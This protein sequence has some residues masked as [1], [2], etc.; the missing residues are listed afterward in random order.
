[1]ATPYQVPRLSDIMY[2]RSR[3]PTPQQVTL[4]NLMSFLKS[5]QQIKAETE[6][7]RSHREFTKQSN[8]EEREW[9]SGEETKRRA[10]EEEKEL[11]RRFE[12]RQDIRR[13][14]NQRLIDENTRRA[15]RASNFIR[16]ALSAGK[17]E[18]ASTLLAGSLTDF[19]N[20]NRMQDVDRYQ[21]EIDSGRTRKSG[22]NRVNAKVLEV[23]RGVGEISA[24]L[25]TDDWTT[26]ADDND[27]NILLNYENRNFSHFTAVERIFLQ[28]KLK[29]MSA[30]EAQIAESIIEY[31]GRGAFRD[32]ETDEP[33][34]V[35]KQLY[36]QK[37]NLL[38]ER[39]SLKNNPSAFLP[40]HARNKSTLLD[41]GYG[42]E[43]LDDAIGTWIKMV[44]PSFATGPIERDTP[45]ARAYIHGLLEAGEAKAIYTGGKVSSIL[46]RAQWQAAGLGMKQDPPLD[47]DPKGPKKIKTIDEFTKELEERIQVKIED[48]IPAKGSSGVMGEYTHNIS[49][50]QDIKDPKG[51]EYP[52]A[53]HSYVPNIVREYAGLSQEIYDT[54]DGATAGFKKNINKYKAG[55]DNDVQKEIKTTLVNS[56]NQRDAGMA[57]ML[58]MRNKIQQQIR[59]PNTGQY[60]KL[61]FIKLLQKITR[62]ITKVDNFFEYMR[63]THPELSPPERVFSQKRRWRPRG[64]LDY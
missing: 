8:I 20:A 64:H 55:L 43:Q 35:L 53:E 30:A 14:E 49:Y 7:E 13:N 26:Y 23:T 54:M 57:T 24:L 25:N 42:P 40:S 17:I 52:L 12:R 41:Y 62:E 28:D 1:M 27:R 2:T 11:R 16:S 45:D 15:D 48:G 33:T 31:E 61:H 5:A 59:N 37:A 22:E 29:S 46:T 19:E 63:T 50:L 44:K 58:A 21:G 3:T 51:K 39:S 18:H 38:D 6:A 60:E 32:D 10:V 47:E 34:G 36:E 9:R 56:L 4:N